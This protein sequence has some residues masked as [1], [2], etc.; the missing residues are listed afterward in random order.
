MEVKKYIIKKDKN[1]VRSVA[2]KYKIDYQ[3]KLNS[4][5]YEA[6]STIDGP[7]L[8]IAGAGTGKTRTLT[9]RVAYFIESGIS[10][11]NILLLTFTRKAA[12]EMLRRVEILIEMN[13]EKVNGGTFHSFATSILR[14][15]AQYLK[16]DNSFSIL[17]ESDA[18]DVINLLRT[19]FKFDTEKKRFPK[20]DT[21]KDIFSKAI[22]TVSKIEEVLEKDYPYYSMFNEKIGK[23]FIEYNQYK[24]KYSLM[25]YDDLLLNLVVLFNEQPS[26]RSN[27]Q[28]KFKYLMVDEYQDTNKIQ[29]EIVKLIGEKHKNVMAVGDDSQSIYS[30][31]GANFRN[32]LEFPNFFPGTKIIKLEQNYRSTQ[33]ILEVTNEIINKSVEKYQ[34]TLYSFKNSEMKPWIVIGESEEFQSLFITQKILELREEGYKLKDIAVLF[35][36]SFHSF[37]LEIE[38]SK[39][40]IP[41]RKFGGFKFVE[42]AHIKDIVA[43]L[44][45]LNNPKD[46]VSWNRILLLVEGIGPRKAQIIIN[47]IENNRIRIDISR[48]YFKNY[49]KSGEKLD[50]LFNLLYENFSDKISISE[51]I[52]NIINYYEPIFKDKFDDFQKR[53]KDIEI[54]QSI[55]E[56]YSNLDNFLV[57]LALEPPDTSVLDINPENKENE[58]LTLSTIHSSKGL[59]WNVVFIISA[60]EGRFP[61]NRAIENVDELEEER[62][63]MYVGCTRAKDQLF[64]CYPTNIYDRENGTILMKPSRFISDIEKKLIEQVNITEEEDINLLES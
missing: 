58:F 7:L 64:I 14:K 1:I 52:Q 3:N 8:V 62:R 40:N 11:E 27:M 50:N 32:I 16:Y 13:C 26:I 60:L 57:D 45:V 61:S 48:E 28:S 24:R 22:N 63:L 42:T 47:D 38:L 10:P 37:D 29:A 53:R 21:L 35:R 17:D 6:V 36:S 55:V 20:K 49:G 18:Q 44:R 31:R 46:V 25:D 51:K 12:R 9:Y 15:Y 39:C 19:N 56:R 43:H 23:L 2:H 54:L 41:F 30:F 4:A 34:K 59:E 5:Q 33:P